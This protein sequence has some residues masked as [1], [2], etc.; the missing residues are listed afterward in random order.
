MAKKSKNSQLLN[1]TQTK[2]LILY[3]DYLT[4]RGLLPTREIIR[5]FALEIARKQVS[6]L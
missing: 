6:K 5:N 4:A 1:N 2:E 3:I